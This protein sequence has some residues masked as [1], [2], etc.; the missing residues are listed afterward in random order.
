MLISVDESIQ[1]L[2]VED[3]VKQLSEFPQ[4]MHCLMIYPD[5]I[6][7]REFYTSYIKKQI[8]EKNRVVLLNPFYET[9][10]SVRRAFSDSHKA[11]DPKQYESTESFI[12]NDSLK[13]YFEQSNP[14]N[15]KKKL[16]EH[17]TRNGKDGLVVIADLGPYF[18]KMNH[19]KLLEYESS[20]PSS[21]GTSMSGLCIY[22]QLDFN[23]LSKEQKRELAGAHSLTL[24]L[25]RHN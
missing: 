15:S 3:M 7:L 4:G 20:L 14:M 1:S 2:K 13:E 6:T 11:I 8:E 17:A 10:S 9:V 16:L 19:D 5:L 12:I 22:H 23:R 24:K 18:F 25:E 21:F